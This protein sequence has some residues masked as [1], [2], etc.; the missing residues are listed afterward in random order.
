MLHIHENNPGLLKSINAIIANRGINVMGQYLE[1][2][3]DIGYVVLDVEPFKSRKES[4][5]LRTAL[6]EIKGT[7]RTRVLY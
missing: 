4:N 5:D 7:I 3:N 6:E 1:T 2:R